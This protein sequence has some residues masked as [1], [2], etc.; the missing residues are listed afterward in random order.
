[1]P[2]NFLLFVQFHLC[3]F[4]N[5][6]ILHKGNTVEVNLLRDDQTKKNI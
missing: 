6:N 3:T 1:M 4:F 5:N 2:I